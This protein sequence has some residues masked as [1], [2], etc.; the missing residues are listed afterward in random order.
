MLRGIGR[1]EGE[2]RTRDFMNAW[3][4][5]AARKQQ[6]QA[7][8]NIRLHNTARFRIEKAERPVTDVVATLNPNPK[9]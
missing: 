4:D 2:P 6:Q 7:A 8:C 3:Q 1:Y 9:A 5:V